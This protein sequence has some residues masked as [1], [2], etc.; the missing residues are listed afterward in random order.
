MSDRRRERLA[1]RIK[2]EASHVILYELQDP[3]IGFLT[4]VR[5]KLSA[6]L[7]QA[8]IH[9]SIMGSE[10]EEKRALAALDH[11]RGYIQGLLSDRLGVRRCPSISFVLD[12]TVKRGLRISSLIEQVKQE[13]AQEGTTRT[14][15]R[16]QGKAD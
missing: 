2:E 4:V 9:V 15:R 5:V 6:D 11:A 1:Q 10:A 14:A 16:S 13:R 3:R 7:V 12:D 8:R